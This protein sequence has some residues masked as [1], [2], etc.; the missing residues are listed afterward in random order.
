MDMGQALC[1]IGK[2]NMFTM[3]SPVNRYGGGVPPEE[4][5]RIPKEGQ[6]QLGPFRFPC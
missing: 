5:G 2:S 1:W 4:G 3:P 6:L